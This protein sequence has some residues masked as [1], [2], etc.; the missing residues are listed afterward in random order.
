MAQLGS[1]LCSRNP[2]G[3]CLG[4]YNYIAA[5]SRRLGRQTVILCVYISMLALRSPSQQ[6]GDPALT[7]VPPAPEFLHSFP[8]TDKV[9]FAV[10]LC[11]VLCYEHRSRT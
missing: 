10:F 5:R 8:L 7:A 4:M 11:A 6:T 1:A 2:V 3:A 9:L